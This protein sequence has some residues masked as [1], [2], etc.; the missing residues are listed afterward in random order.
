[1]KIVLMFLI[2][3]GCTYIGV[4]LK[5][6]FFTKKEIYGQLVALC[7]KYKQEVGFLKTDVYSAVQKC[8]ESNS[9]LNGIINNFFSDDKINHPQLSE[10]EKQ[11]VFNFLDGLGK[12]DVEGEIKYAEFYK[13]LF[14]QKQVKYSEQYEKFGGF[15]VKMSAIMGLLICIILA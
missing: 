15:S 9:V 10:S 11:E 5:H 12:Q 7:E 8:V 2:F 13:I 3:G 4:Q 1:M 14:E 6:N